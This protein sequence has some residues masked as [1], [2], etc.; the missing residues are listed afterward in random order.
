MLSKKERIKIEKK[1][2]LELKEQL[3]FNNSNKSV[4]ITISMVLVVFVLFYFITTLIVGE[5]GIKY[6]DKTPTEASIQYVEILAGE[7]FSMP[8]D[9]YY[10]LFYDFDAPNASYY[11]TLV[12]ADRDT[13][14]YSVD[15][16]NRFNT[17]YVSNT[18]NSKVQKA[19]DLKVKDATLIKIKNGKNVM[20]FEGS[21][22]EIKEK[23][24]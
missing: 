15:L 9:E 2:K 8:V 20:Y 16:S 24:K 14:L 22:L 4:I 11:S 7:T 17:D 18:T 21:L 19:S 13:K 1:K 5:R 12:S 6:T 10:V 3:D 23:L